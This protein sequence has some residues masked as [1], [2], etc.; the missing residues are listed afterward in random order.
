MSN[1]LS[2]KICDFRRNYN[3]QY[4][5]TYML[6]KRK[7]TLDKGKHVFIDLSKA[8]DT[9]NHD[10]LMAQLKAYGFSNNVL[11]FMLSCLKNRSQRVSINTS[12][13][14]WEKIIAGVPQESIPGPLSQTNIFLNDIFYF[15]NRCYLSNYAD[16]NV[17]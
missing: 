8:F 16:D 2:I 17:L 11:L 1:K 13:S 10:L 3:T 6:E 12:F 5:F 9:L 15:E 4:C 14:T 7:N